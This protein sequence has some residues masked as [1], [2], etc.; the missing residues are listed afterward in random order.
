MDRKF[1]EHVGYF[2]NLDLVYKFRVYDNYIKLFFAE[3]AFISIRSD[4]NGYETIVNYM[5]S[6]INDF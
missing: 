3:E 6:K 2:Y 5:Q 1:I 4:H